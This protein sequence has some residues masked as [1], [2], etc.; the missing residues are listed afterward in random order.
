MTA[1]TQREL[2]EKFQNILDSSDGFAFF[3]KIHD[4]V[5]YIETRAPLSAAIAERNKSNRELK[6]SSKYESLKQIYQGL[7]DVKDKPHGDLGH[8]RYMIVGDLNRIR[9]KEYSEN[10]TFWKKRDGYKKF[11]QDIY[12]RLTVCS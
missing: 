12:N 3:V 6:I 1:K 9:N 8:V 5:E 11:A 4:F 10:I 2:D 7:E